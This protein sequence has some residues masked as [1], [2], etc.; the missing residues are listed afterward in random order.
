MQFQV[1]Q[2]IEVEDKIFGPLTFRQFI[3]C[4]GAAGGAYLL[5]R[6]LPLIIALPLIGLVAGTGAALAFFKYNDRPFILGAENMFNYLIHPKLYLW[7]NANPSTPKAI[8]IASK[9]KQAQIY[10]PSLSESRLSNLAW[11]LDIQERIAAGVADEIERT[12][13]NERE[14]VMAIITTA[15]TATR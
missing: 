15:R 6:L 8:S 12:H 7:S 14:D 4:A 13:E 5:W 10:V 2:F 9:G 11:S 3:Y 1:P